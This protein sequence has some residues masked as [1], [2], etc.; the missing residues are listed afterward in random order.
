MLLFSA[1][2][3]TIPNLYRPMG[4]AGY[5][6]VYTQ[7]YASFPNEDAAGNV[8]SNIKQ[9]VVANSLSIP[10]VVVASVPFNQL[11]SSNA[12]ILDALLGYSRIYNTI[13][14][15][16]DVCAITTPGNYASSVNTY[17]PLMKAVNPVVKICV[18]GRN[19]GDFQTLMNTSGGVV[20]YL[21]GNDVPAMA[22][23]IFSSS[24]SP[25]DKARV[26]LILK[27]DTFSGVST[28]AAN[29]LVSYVVVDKC[30]DNRNMY[31]PLGMVVNELIN[32]G[33]NV[34]SGNTTTITTENIVISTANVGGTY[35]Q[36]RIFGG[37]NKK[38][39]LLTPLGDGDIHCL[40]SKVSNTSVCNCSVFIGNIG[41]A[42][43]VRPSINMNFLVDSD[44]NRS[45]GY[46]PISVAMANLNPEYIRFSGEEA[47]GY[48]WATAPSWVP[49]SHTLNLTQPSQFP[50]G[51]TAY[52]SPP[53]N[54]GS[55]N[56][57]V[58]NYDQIWAVANAANAKM[59]NTICM[60][61]MYNTLTPVSKALLMETAGR[62]VKYAKDSGK[63]AAMYELGNETDMDVAYNG[64]TTATQYAADATEFI[65]N[66]RAYDA[67]IYTLVNAS[68]FSG[69]QI[70]NSIP[71]ANAVVIHSYPIFEFPGNT[72]YGSG[73]VNYIEYAENNYSGGVYYANKLNIFNKSI[74][75]ALGAVT[76]P[77]HLTETNV[78]DFSAYNGGVGWPLANDVSRML[79]LAD[80]FI[81]QSLKVA[82]WIVWSTRWT[83]TPGKNSN[84]LFGVFDNFNG[85]LPTGHAFR[86]ISLATRDYGTVL[87]SCSTSQYIKILPIIANGIIRIL[88]VNKSANPQ[89]VD[90]QLN[91]NEVVEHTVIY[92]ERN[93]STVVLSA[94]GAHLVSQ[95]HI[96][97][98]VRPLS[99]SLIKTV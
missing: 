26:K 30:F 8:I 98:R 3:Y 86:M 85:F 81:A 35:Y 5:T 83:D 91:V 36:H 45:P 78:M 49:S 23:G 6:T 75:T 19:S 87:N 14:L 56:A 43:V 17:A 67:S 60:N 76:K 31:T 80:M 25:A 62:W 40:Y 90:I 97:T 92:G 28:Y 82:S 93:D 16:Q 44:L 32:V 12:S 15:G 50:A 58:M 22:S 18:N 99:I 21:V 11:F 59:I 46:I 64:Y 71:N 69:W 53:G 51:D 94:T 88:I 61:S 95:G 96:Y 70:V 13:E 68:T 66:M 10:N 55:L 63:T 79:L 29:S 37:A 24:A 77:L 9:L 20:D 65:A 4:S 7:N 42:P 57:N 74:D 27:T 54:N 2:V 73:N 72:A 41:I 48:S 52:W 1:N 38:V 33:G 39:P 84:L 47:Q 34:T 89:D